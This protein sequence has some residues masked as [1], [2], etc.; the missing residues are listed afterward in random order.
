MREELWERWRSAGRRVRV[1]VPYGAPLKFNPKGPQAYQLQ[2]AFI[3]ASNITASAAVRLHDVISIGAGV[4][5]VLGFAEL[6]KLQDRVPPFPAH[7]S[8]AL[9]ERALGRRIADV[10]TTGRSTG[11]HLHYEV[12]VDGKPLNAM[13]L[14]LPTGRKLAEDP[15][16]LA[17]FRQH[18]PPSTRCAQ[19][20]QRARWPLLHRVKQRL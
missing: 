9:I 1:Y 19:A 15:A 11:P 2:Q 3:V 10:G 17:E 7:Q 12:Y 16:M 5:Y 6:A 20:A 4:S 8:A 13:S 14:K 18:K